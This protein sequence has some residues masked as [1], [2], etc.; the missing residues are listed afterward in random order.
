[1]ISVLFM[2]MLL[3]IRASGA[4]KMFPVP[5]VRS[6]DT[7][8]TNASSCMDLRIIVTSSKVA[9]WQSRC[10]GSGFYSGNIQ[11]IQNFVHRSANIQTIQNS[12][13][14]F[15]NLAGI[16]PCFST[17]QSLFQHVWIV[18]SGTVITCAMIWTISLILSSIFQNQLLSLYLMVSLFLLKRMAMLKFLLI[19]FLKEFFIF[20]VWS[21]FH[22]KI[23]G[24]E[25]SQLHDQAAA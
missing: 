3:R 17:S 24:C 9:V 18:D 6:I 4:R 15:S 12:G 22:N 23:S 8:S 10:T 13:E 14:A 7:L 19:S 11:T 2:W 25:R 5:T 1:M 20:Q 21:D 16:N